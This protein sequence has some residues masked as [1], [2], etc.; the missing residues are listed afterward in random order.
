MLPIK[1]EFKDTMSSE[2]TINDAFF[3][4]YMKTHITKRPDGR[5]SLRLPWKE[6]H[7]PLPCNY[8]VCSRRTRSLA[9]QLAKTPELMKQYGNII[10]DQ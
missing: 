1:S 10:E 3:Q 5:Y 9:Y 2:D 7:Q 8:S 6:G 4:Q